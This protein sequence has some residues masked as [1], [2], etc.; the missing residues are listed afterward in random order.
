V[1]DPKFDSR[2]KNKGDF[3]SPKL[4]NPLWGPTQPSIKG[5]RDDFPWMN[6]P[7][8]EFDI[9]P[10][11]NAGVNEWSYTSTPLYAGI[12]SFQFFR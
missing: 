8:S 11:P 6:R 2:Q 9:S 7:V 10:P 12:H 1:E 4:S 5:Y 3:C